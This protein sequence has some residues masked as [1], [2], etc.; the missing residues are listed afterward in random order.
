MVRI[1][2]HSIG[3]TDR[4]YVH[5]ERDKCTL[6]RSAGPNFKRPLSDMSQMEGRKKLQLNLQT[7]EANIYRSWKPLDVEALHTDLAQV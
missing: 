4:P 2:N 7:T 3:N 1:I 6:T 5:S